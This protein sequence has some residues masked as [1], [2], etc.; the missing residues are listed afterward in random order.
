MM[1][2][3]L[4]EQYGQV[5]RVCVVEREL[6]V[7]DVGEDAVG[8]EAERAEARRADAGRGQLQELPSR[9]VHVVGSPKNPVA[10]WSASGLRS[11]PGFWGIAVSGGHARPPPRSLMMR[12]DMARRAVAGDR[13]VRAGR[14]P[15]SLRG[16][17]AS[18]DP[19]YS[20]CP[21]VI[22]IEDVAP[23][24]REA[25]YAVR[26]P[27]VS[28]AQELERQ[29][30]EVIYCNIGNP[31]SLGQRPLSWVRQ[32][33]ALAEYPELLDRV[34]AGTFP[35]DVVEVAREVAPRVRARARRLHR[36]QGLP[37]RARRGRR[38]HP[39]A[40]RHRRRP[41]VRST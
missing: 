4:T 18:P 10:P 40:R 11:G 12:R 35:A 29:G 25:Q 21:M 36:E 7:A 9:E 16:L 14:R 3:Q 17:A 32:V 5:F 15:A 28:R 20:R 41:R 27:I 39:R 38:L 31:Q 1:M 37:V 6:E 23:F 19:V 13:R 22:R 26:G 2:P 34:P 30:R 33:L 24:V 8:S